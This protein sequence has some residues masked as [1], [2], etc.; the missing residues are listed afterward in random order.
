[1]VSKY[2]LTPEMLA[3]QATWDERRWLKEIPDQD[4]VAVAVLVLL[5]VALVA[6]LLLLGWLVVQL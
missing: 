1:M 4:P 3:D 2:P 5:L 6:A